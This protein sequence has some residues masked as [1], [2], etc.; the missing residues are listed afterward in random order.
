MSAA[1]ASVLAG[2][3]GAGIQASRT[4]AMHEHEG[5][6][7]GLRLLYQKIDLER[8]GLGPEALPELLQA[9]ERMGFSGLNITHPCKQAVL[10]LLVVMLLRSV[11]F[12]MTLR[13]IKQ[14]VVV[15]IVYTIL[16]IKPVAL[17]LLITRQV[18]T[19]ILNLL[20]L[21]TPKK[22]LLNQLVVMR[23]LMR[24]LLLTILP[25]LQA[26][27]VLHSRMKKHQSIDICEL[28]TVR[29]K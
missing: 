7:Q 16:Q 29:T 22:M 11:G 14:L 10:P 27:C 24:Q 1:H 19:F 17:F 15:E 9:A 8:L 18:I 21:K 28:G 6:A 20:P 12:L 26:L 23:L 25:I 2:L 4:P 13:K 3:I 5:D